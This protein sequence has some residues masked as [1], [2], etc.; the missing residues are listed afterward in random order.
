MGILPS[1]VDAGMNNLNGHRPPFDLDAEHRP[2]VR[3]LHTKDPSGVLMQ[4]V[5]LMDSVEEWV[6]GRMDVGGAEREQIRSRQRRLGEIISQYSER[7]APDND[8]L[9]QLLAWMHSSEAFYALDYITLAQP[10]FTVQFIRHCQE[11][12]GDDINARLA[13]ERISTLYRSRVLDRVYSPENVERVTSV[14]LEM[15]Q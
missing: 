13:L 7:L 10:N 6:L 4:Q 15:M 5:L 1:D 9:C 8:A 14:L 11:N 2:A 12:G 3:F